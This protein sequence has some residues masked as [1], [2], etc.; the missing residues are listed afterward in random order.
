MSG[1]QGAHPE[2]ENRRRAHEQVPCDPDVSTDHV[3]DFLADVPCGRCGAKRLAGGGNRCV[4][5]RLRQ[6]AYCVRT[7]SGCA[8][9]AH[10]RCFC[11]RRERVKLPAD[12]RGVVLLPLDSGG[13][14]LHGARGF[15]DGQA[16]A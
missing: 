16:A 5:C 4:Y 10:R 13:L 6:G 8:Q 7:E 9:P 14:R 3:F 12:H 2:C 1:E 11:R 15:R